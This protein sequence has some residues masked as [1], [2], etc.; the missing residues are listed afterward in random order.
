MKERL[1]DVAPQLFIGCSPPFRVE[2]ILGRQKTVVWH[3]GRAILSRKHVFLNESTMKATA[4]AIEVLLM[5]TRTIFTVDAN[6]NGKIGEKKIP[7]GSDFLF[8][9]E[10]ASEGNEMGHVAI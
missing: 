8:L 7:F 2:S 6:S 1:F 10:N 9:Y 4:T 5:M 3:C